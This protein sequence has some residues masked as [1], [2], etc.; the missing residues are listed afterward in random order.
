VSTSA[1]TLRRAGAASFAIAFEKPTN[2]R[3]R[4]DGF[5][6]TFLRMLE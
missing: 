6:P 5:I 3:A 1:G 2:N 4:W